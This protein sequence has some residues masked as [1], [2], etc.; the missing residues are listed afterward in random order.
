MGPLL[1]P[2]REALLRSGVLAVEDEDRSTRPADVGL[3]CWRGESAGGAACG[4]TSGNACLPLAFFFCGS[5]GLLLIHVGTCA[6][7]FRSVDATSAVLLATEGGADMRVDVLKCRCGRAV[8]SVGWGCCVLRRNLVAGADPSWLGGGIVSASLHG[9]GYSRAST[10]CAGCGPDSPVLAQT[11]TCMSGWAVGMTCCVSE[12][13]LGAG[14][15][16]LG[17]R[18]ANWSFLAK[19]RGWSLTADRVVSGWVAARSSISFWTVFGGAWV[20]ECG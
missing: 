19:R 15:D 14:W 8:F 20:G 9:T 7:R 17:E 3:C 18:G 12:L 5:S 10:G 2:R 4:A 11:M 6:F 16:A 1:R 13:E